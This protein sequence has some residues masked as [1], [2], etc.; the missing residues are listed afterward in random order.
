[1]MKKYMLV[2]LFTGSYN[3]ENTGHEI[4]ND[5]KNSITRKYYGYLP[6]HDDPNI[7]NLGASK[8]DEYIDDILIVFVR[9]ISDETPCRIVTGFY[10][11]ARV[12]SKKQS[13][14]KLGRRFTDKDGSVKVASYTMESERYYPVT[15]EFALLIETRKYNSHM[16]RKQRVYCGKYPELDDLVIDYIGRLID[17]EALEDDIIAQQ[18][19]QE[20]KGANNDTIQEAPNRMVKLEN[21]PSGK[22]VLRNPELAKS[23]IIRAQNQCEVDASHATFINKRGKPYMEGHHLIP[24]TEKNATSIWHQFN[25]NIDCIEN[26]VSLCPTCHRAIHLGNHTEKRKILNELLIRRLPGLKQININ[27]NEKYVMRLYGLD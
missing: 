24:C 27:V 25:R 7:Q 8:N 22:K 18:E 14:E 26:I 20:I 11:N 23:A 1:M 19:L 17:G 4:L 9:R 10:P 5:V 12:Y 3:E 15:S 21:Q 2:D 6:P 13:G 16:F